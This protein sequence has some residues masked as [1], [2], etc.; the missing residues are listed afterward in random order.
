MI[1]SK[2]CLRSTFLC[3]TLI[4][5]T[6]LAE[7]EFPELTGRVVDDAELLS[8][9]F[10]SQ[11][12][13]RLAG[14][15]QA[16]SIQVV[17]ATITTL[18]GYDIREYGV[19]LARAWQLGQREKDNGILFL[20][21]DEER[22]ASIEIGYGL[23]GDFP[24]VIA[25]HILNT[26][27]FPVFRQG[28]YESGIMRGVMR[29]EEVLA[30]TY[31]PPPLPQQRPQQRKPKLAFAPLIIFLLIFTCSG[32]F[33][34]RRRGRSSGAGGILTGVMVG[35]ALSSLGGRSGAGFGGGGMGGFSGGGGSFGGGG[36]SGGW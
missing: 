5:A 35:S 23:E 18:E 21:A 6:V 33:R 26:D 25:F 17:V 22:R 20:V 13:A 34:G 10:E 36:A 4:A 32:F 1:R 31:E 24:D 12:S 27:V 19:Q 9:A 16:S 29:I 2:G 14:L 7:P 11:L 30:G 15:E 3:F 8:P 28:D